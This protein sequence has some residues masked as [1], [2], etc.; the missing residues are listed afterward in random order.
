MG[1]GAMGLNV[2]LLQYKLRFLF[3]G[4]V[5]E[6]EGTGAMTPN[7]IVPATPPQRSLPWLPRGHCSG[8]TRGRAICY[9]SSS[10]DFILA[11]FVTL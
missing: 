1:K 11:F 10:Y 3:W 9:I 4:E 2:P 5:S 8:R 7:A 6:V